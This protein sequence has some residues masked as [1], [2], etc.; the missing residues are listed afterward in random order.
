MIPMIMT[1]PD[2]T[3]G[4][5]AIVI[6][7]DEDNGTSTNKV[8]TVVAHPDLHGVVT[9]ASIN[10]Y[11]LTRFQEQVAG[12]SAYLNNA[13]TAADMGQAFGLTVGS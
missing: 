1:G 5:L 8:L 11:S 12:V 4:H 2:W 10:S 7:A 9:A 3:S 6:T 13:A